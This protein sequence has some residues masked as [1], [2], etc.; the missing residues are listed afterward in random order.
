MDR[1]NRWD[2][3]ELAYNAIVNGVGNKAN[4]ACDAVTQSYTDG[5]NDEFV[6]PTVINPNGMISDG[7]AVIFCNF[8]PD[9]ARELTKAL[10][11]PDLKVLNENLYLSLWR[12]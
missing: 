2:R 4:S 3:E 9:R 10:T 1:D 7:D 5:V 12:Q 11:V 6:V 8:R